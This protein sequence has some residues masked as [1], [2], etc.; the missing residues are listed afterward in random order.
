[1]KLPKWISNSQKVNENQRSEDRL[2]DKILKVLGI[3][4]DTVTDDIQMSITNNR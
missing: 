1:M 4:W 2:K 3:V